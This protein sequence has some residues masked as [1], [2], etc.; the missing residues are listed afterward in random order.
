MPGADVLKNFQLSMHISHSFAVLQGIGSVSL[1]IV[2]FCPAYS[3][4]HFLRYLSIQFILDGEWTFR[5]IYCL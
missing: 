5:S 1:S 3:Q 2:T 4:V